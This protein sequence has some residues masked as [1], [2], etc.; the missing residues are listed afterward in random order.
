MKQVKVVPKESL[1]IADKHEYLMLSMKKYFVDQMK[2]YREI[3]Y[4]KFVEKLKEKFSMNMNQWKLEG[5]KKFD[6]QTEFKKNTNQLYPVQ[7][8]EN[9][10]TP[11]KKEDLPFILYRHK[12]M[13]HSKSD[14]KFNLKLANIINKE[15]IEDIKPSPPKLDITKIIKDSEELPLLFMEPTLKKRTEEYLNIEEGAHYKEALE[16]PQNVCVKYAQFLSEKDYL[17]AFAKSNCSPVMITPGI[18]STKLV[19]K[20][21]CPVMKEK[22][23]EL[24]KT[25]GWTSCDFGMMK[26]VPADEYIIWMPDLLNDLNLLSINQKKND[27]W[28]KLFGT[29]LNL[30]SVKNNDYDNLFVDTWKDLGWEV[31][32]FGSTESSKHNHKC[33]SSAIEYLLPYNI[34]AEGLGGTKRLLDG[35]RL[36]GYRDGVSLQS[37]PYD[38]RYASGL[39]HGYKRSFKQSLKRIKRLTGKKTIVIAHS[40][41]TVNSYSSILDLTEEEKEEL[42]D[43]WA[44]IGGPLMGSVELLGTLITGDNP[45]SFLNGIIGLTKS[46]SLNSFYGSTFTFDMIPFNYWKFVNE[47]WFKEFVIPRALSERKTA[48]QEIT[49]PSF[50]PNPQNECYKNLQGSP[51]KCIF[52][53]GIFPDKEIIQMKDKTYSLSE[54]PELMEDLE[55][56]IPEK[57]P[58][59][60]KKLL[61]LTRGNYRDYPHPNVPVVGFFLNIKKTQSAMQFKEND[62]VYDKLQQPEN[63]ILDTGDATVETYSA[64]LPML[65]WA[66]EYSHKSNGG[67]KAVKFVDV[68]SKISREAHPFDSSIFEERFKNNAY[69]GNAH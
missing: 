15:L 34:S 27:C 23:P 33:G 9:L 59:H 39:N 24:F 18:F 10:L 38:F 45:L 13:N 58:V 54:M 25:C 41:G 65:K 51:I 61:E 68:C 2:I 63:I 69:I 5:S 17:R 11:D 12:S 29:P 49:R 3:Q 30:E 22:S 46:Q 16:N 19:V 62:F 56:V 60:F 40:F 8:V 36:M 64:I 31:K 35:L 57:Q 21:N 6:D 14:A 48:T 66:Y 26:I 53:W 28:V 20:I 43:F 50:F 7:S 55:K 52:L 37:L 32:I 44:P 42:I 1:A 4:I 67:T 47:D